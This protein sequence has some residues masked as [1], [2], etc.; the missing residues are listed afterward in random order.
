MG[1]MPFSGDTLDAPHV[2]I[3]LCTKNGSAFL[4]EQLRSLSAQTHKNWTLYAS[5]DASTDGTK[6]ILKQFAATA[7]S[8]VIL[9]EGPQKGFCHNFLRL[10]T[11][12]SIRAD[13]FAFCDQDDIWYPE[14]L[15]RAIKSLS[16]FPD[17]LPVL[18]SSRVELIDAAGTH[19]GYSLLFRR[20]PSFKN[21][22]VQSIA[23]GNTLVFNKAA[24]Q[25]AERAG[26]LEV[27]AHD[28]WLYLLV[29]SAGG[30]VHYDAQPSLKYRQHQQNAIGS[31]TGWG[32]RIHRLR[33]LLSNR[34]R[35]WN[36]L[37]VTALEACA[38]LMSADH[39]TT[40]LLF[41]QARSASSGLSRMHA[42]RRAGLY[43]QT[44]LGNLALVA[45]AF[46]GK[47]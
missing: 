5:D 19:R 10:L 34:F 6:E 40:F 31:N 22:L 46:F 12:P 28:W 26:V 47:I 29:S 14:K 23:G 7:G 36:T 32:S 20:K 9:R 17:D 25:L 39:R 8:P 38:H 16:K 43:R 33:M 45:A 13:L 44:I 42:L 1:A 18:Y 24:K 30:I 35:D 37:N 11:D 3:L 21:A 4:D 2:A 41:N 15:E 27:V